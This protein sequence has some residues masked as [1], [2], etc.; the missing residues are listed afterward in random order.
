MTDP[1]IIQGYTYPLGDVEIGTLEIRH[2]SIVSETGDTGVIRL[3]SEEVTEAELQVAPYFE[4]RLEPDAPMD[5]GAVVKFVRS[6]IQITRPERS[7]TGVPQMV[8][9]VQNAD[10]RIGEGIYAVAQTAIPVECTYRVF[11][12]GTR[13]NGAPDILSG[14]ELVN[15]ELS[16]LEVTVRAQGPDVVNRA[17]HKARYDNRF[18]LLGL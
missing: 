12:R 16:L 11:T 17:F 1:A 14:L 13:Y 10:Q 5:G 8:L 15:P 6:T 7:T 3:A 9:R 2:P 4:A 18:P